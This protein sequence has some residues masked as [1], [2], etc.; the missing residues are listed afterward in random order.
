MLSV[1]WGPTDPFTVLVIDCHLRSTK[2]FFSFFFCFLL[3]FL[4]TFF[5]LFYTISFCYHLYNKKSMTVII[6]VVL[7]FG[8][9]LPKKEWSFQTISMTSPIYELSL[10]LL[11][12]LFSFLFLFCISFSIFEFIRFSFQNKSLP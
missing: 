9:L 11:V 1:Y 8:V 2:F 5:I 6:T 3:L 7:L 4:S 12:I 10:H